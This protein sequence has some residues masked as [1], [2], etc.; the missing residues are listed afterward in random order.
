[1]KKKIIINELKWKRKNNLVGK[2]NRKE[3]DQKTD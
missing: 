2:T 3:T 1:M